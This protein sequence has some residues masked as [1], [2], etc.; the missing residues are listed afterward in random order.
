MI[1]IYV[2]TVVYFQWEV[3]C[4]NPLRKYKKPILK[5]FIL[6]SGQN[7]FDVWFHFPEPIH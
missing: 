4:E 3:M 5:L 6:Y 1:Y 7:Y 2:H